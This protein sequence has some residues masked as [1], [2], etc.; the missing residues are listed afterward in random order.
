LWSRKVQQPVDFEELKKL[1][2]AFYEM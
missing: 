1:E 2:Q